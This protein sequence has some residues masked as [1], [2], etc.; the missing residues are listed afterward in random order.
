MSA[1]SPRPQS[2][3]RTRNAIGRRCAGIRR[4]GHSVPLHQQCQC[5][6][7]L[8]L[9]WRL[10]SVVGGSC[11]MS[12]NV[13]G[14]CRV[15]TSASCCPCRRSIGVAS[16]RVGSDRG[17]TRL[18]SRDLNP[19]PGTPRFD[20]ILRPVVFGVVLLEE[21][22]HVLGALSGPEHQIHV[23]VLVEPQCRF[24]SSRR[25]RGSLPP[26]TRADCAQKLP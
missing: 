21:R 17:S 10:Y 3:S 14:R 24:S 12:G 16:G 18:A 13:S 5:R 15:P 20:D 2:P 26:S 19:Y 22:E 1:L 9:R 8:R 25:P 23:L 4:Y 11:G 7:E 6:R